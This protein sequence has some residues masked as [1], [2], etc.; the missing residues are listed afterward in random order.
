MEASLVGLVITTIIWL[1]KGG[2]GIKS[3]IGL[4][5]ALL[6]AVA[7]AYISTLKYDKNLFTKGFFEL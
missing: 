6:W 3:S 1:K 7:G 5:F 2:H 4:W